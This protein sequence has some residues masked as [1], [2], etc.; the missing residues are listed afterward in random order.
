MNICTRQHQAAHTHGIGHLVIA[1]RYYLPWQSRLS[2]M[3]CARPGLAEGS[4]Q[5]PDAPQDAPIYGV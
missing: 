2:A 1:S 3:R 4:T 5:G